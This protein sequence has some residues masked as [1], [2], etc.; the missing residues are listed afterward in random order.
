MAMY[1]NNDFV[2]EAV[3]NLENVIDVP[4]DI[5]TNR[6]QYNA[7]LNI[8]DIQFIVEAKSTMR[9]S[10]QGLVLSKLEELKEL[11]VRRTN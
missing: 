6:G 3:A 5:E 4:I 1:H 2:Y 10:N 8:K 11:E 9:T 7:I